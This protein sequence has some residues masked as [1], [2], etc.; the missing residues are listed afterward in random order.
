MSSSI[1]ERRCPIDLSLVCAGLGLPYRRASGVSLCDVKGALSAARE[2]A[3]NG[4][5]AVVELDITAFNQHAGPTPGWPSDPMRIALED[6]LLLGGDTDPLRL[7]HQALGSTE[8]DR[9]S[10]QVMQENRVG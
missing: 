9:L 5:P 10:E 2:A 7:L 6:G 1:E 3:S 4:Q 8:F